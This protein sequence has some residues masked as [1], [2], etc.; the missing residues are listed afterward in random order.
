MH[1]YIFY[2]YL[3]YWQVVVEGVKTF[4]YEANLYVLTCF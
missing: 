1:V 4:K 3:M 2:I